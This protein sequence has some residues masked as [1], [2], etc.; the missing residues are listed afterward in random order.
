MAAPAPPY[1]YAPSILYDPPVES[2]TQRSRG[3]ES[4]ITCLVCGITRTRIIDCVSTW[5]ASNFESS[6]D[7][8]RSTVKAPDCA[9][10]G[11]ALG[12]GVNSSEVGDGVG[13][14]TFWPEAW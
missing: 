1:E 13:T 2:G 9:A 6:S 5:S 10:E 7:P 4:M 3:I 12:E 14:T 8:S 11:P